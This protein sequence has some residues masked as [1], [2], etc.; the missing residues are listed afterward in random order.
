MAGKAKNGLRRIQIYISDQK[1][2]EMLPQIKTSGLS[3]SAFFAEII[4]GDKQTKRGAPKGNQNARKN[5]IVENTESSIKT[6]KD[7]HLENNYEYLEIKKA[8]IKVAQFENQFAAS[9]EEIE[10]LLDG[11][12]EI[13]QTNSQDFHNIAVPNF[14]EKQTESDADFRLKPIEQNLEQGRLF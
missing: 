9:D 13:N 6:E 2:E 10:F 14:E 11:L 12:S 4:T 5:Q 3:E 7:S 8:E 1:Y